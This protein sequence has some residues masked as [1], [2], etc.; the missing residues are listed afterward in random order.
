VGE[1]V[2]RACLGLP[3]VTYLVFA[4]WPSSALLLQGVPQLQACS[5]R[6]YHACV[7][8]LRLTRAAEAGAD[9]CSVYTGHL[10]FC[11]KLVQQPPRAATP[12]QQY[13]TFA[14]MQAAADVV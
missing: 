7:L 12:K 11:L 13:S 5:K 10:F 3:V 1:S 4:A 2:R 14:G 6:R 8:L 9:G